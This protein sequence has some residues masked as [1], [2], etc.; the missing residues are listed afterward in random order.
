VQWCGGVYAYALTM[1]A[2][3][4]TSLDW[5]HLA[6]GIL[7]CAEQMQYPDGP[8]AGLL[9]D[10]FVLKEQERRPWLINPSALVSLQLALEGEVDFLAVAHD[11]RHRI[12]APFPVTLHDGKAIVRGKPGLAYQVILDG[13]VIDVKSQGDDVI[14]LQ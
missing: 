2:P 6:Q 11:A 7:I 14:L 1:L 5:K 10:S 8:Y 4:D 12:A 3:Y 9:P 13:R